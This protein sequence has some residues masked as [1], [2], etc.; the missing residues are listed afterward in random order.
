MHLFGHH[1]VDTCQSEFTYFSI[2]IAITTL[3]SNN[4]MTPI[5]RTNFA[6]FLLGFVL[7]SVF[8]FIQTTTNSGA[9]ISNA[10]FVKIQQQSQAK[11]LIENE[12]PDILVNKLAEAHED[13]ND[14][15]GDGHQHGQNE[16]MFQHT[17]E[18]T[19]VAGALKQSV[20]VFC[21]IMTAKKNTLS[22]AVH[23]NATWAQRCNKYVFVSV[24]E[25]AAKLPNVDLNVTE[26]RNFLWAKT[27][28]AHQYIY[29]NELDNFDWFLKADDDTYVIMENLRFMLLAYSPSDPVYFGCK[30][31]P[32]TK[33]GY[34]SGGSGYV[35]SR[36]AVKRFVEEGLPDPKKCKQAGTG[37]EDAEI[38]RCLEKINVTAG[39]SRDSRG[40]HRMLPFS[41]LSHLQAGGNKTMPA[42]FYQYMYYPYEQGKECCSDYMIS[43]HY[44]NKGTMYAL[45][46]L[47]YH[48]RPIGFFDDLWTR[49]LG[50]KENAGKEIIDT[51]RAL[52][53]RKSQPLL[54]KATE[55][56]DTDKKAEK[57]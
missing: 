11:G 13:D 2:A 8:Y 38:G 43:F 56:K 6:Y 9:V 44:V 37:A 46:N 47:L 26:G 7:A 27:K 23:V 10:G 34:M 41:P 48:I 50:S 31:K 42:W 4:D 16:G 20:R 51:L 25:T 21:W 39:D 3:G 55:A 12:D 54:P 24:N 52:A 29:D 35:L 33:Q 19:A 18:E 40:R 36:E 28:A 49:E 15:D 45:D 1:F 32:F 30:F 14:E 57:E 53:E 5:R 17:H 22:R